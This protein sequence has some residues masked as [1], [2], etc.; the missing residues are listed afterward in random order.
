MVERLN[1][2]TD[3]YINAWT[4]AEKKE[5]VE[6]L[7]TI[8]SSDVAMTALATLR[9]H[10]SNPDWRAVLAEHID[11][12]RTARQSGIQS[13]F[14]PKLD[15][16]EADVPAALLQRLRDVTNDDEYLYLTSRFATLRTLLLSR[17]L[18]LVEPTQ[19]SEKRAVLMRERSILLTHAAEIAASPQ[20]YPDNHELWQWHETLLRR[21]RT[22]GI[23]EAFRHV[24]VDQVNN[25]IAEYANARTTQEKRDIFDARKSLLGSKVGVE[26]L[27]DVKNRDDKNRTASFELYDVLTG[28][29]IEELPN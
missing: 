22:A 11:V 25:A 6:N 14:D 18:Q 2:A 19:L 17:L 27:L 15:P 10:E 21:A 8:L 4:W 5:V 1:A 29:P 9:D 23:D 26:I 28:H 20:W 13:A 24:M 16:T 3:A 12:L 7:W